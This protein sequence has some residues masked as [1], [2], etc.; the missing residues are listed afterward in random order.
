[1]KEYEIVGLMKSDR[2][3][4]P[5]GTFIVSVFLVFNIQHDQY[6]KTRPKDSLKWLVHGLKINI[7]H[8]NS[9]VVQIKQGLTRSRT[10]ALTGL[11]SICNDRH[12]SPSAPILTVNKDQFVQ[13]R[14]TRKDPT[15]L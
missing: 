11:N 4:M 8:R 6:R 12:L 7:I 14:F 5:N 15:G 2:I 10:L 1:L 9:V 3:R 13:M